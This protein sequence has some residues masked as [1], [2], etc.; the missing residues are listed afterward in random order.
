[1]PSGLQFEEAT[2]LKSLFAK[3][4][5]IIGFDLV[6]VSPDKDDGMPT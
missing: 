1:M 2:Y 3:H 4:R 6:E 5:T